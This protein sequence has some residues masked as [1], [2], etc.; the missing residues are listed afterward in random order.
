[1]ERRQSIAKPSF[2]Q[3]ASLISPPLYWIGSWSYL[4]KTNSPR[5][6]SSITAL[7]EF[8]RQLVHEQQS[9]INRRPSTRL[10][11]CR[12]LPLPPGT[13]SPTFNLPGIQPFP[14]LL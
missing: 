12:T 1:V 8:V 2:R 4:F 11:R 13:A 7:C 9:N 6:I 5:S 3:A 14:A 10:S